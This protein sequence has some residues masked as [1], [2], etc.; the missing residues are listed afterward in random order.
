MR[1][2]RRFDLTQS[3]FL[4]AEEMAE[5]NGGDYLNKVCDGSKIGQACLYTIG[6]DSYSGV[7]T[8]EYTY[9]TGSSTTSSSR[10]FC[11][12]PELRKW[13]FLGLVHHRPCVC[14]CSCMNLNM[15]MSICDS[16]CRI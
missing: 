13:F 9:S 7:C 3:R 2:V 15:Q 5:L 12:V 8:Y 11:D 14:V 1:K 16:D 6:S 10:Y 4:S